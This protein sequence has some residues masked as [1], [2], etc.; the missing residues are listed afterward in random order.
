MRWSRYFPSAWVRRGVVAALLAVTVLPGTALAHGFGSRYEL[1]LPKW[2]F[3]TGGAGVVLVSFVV[4]SVFAGREEGA[5][6]Y[7]ARPLDETPLGP[8][9]STGMVQA[10]RAAAV[11]LL[12]VGVIAGLVGPAE[13]NENLLTNLVWVGWWVGY[14]FSVIFLGNTWPVLNPWTTIYDWTTSLLDRDPTAHREYTWGHLP[15]VVLFVAFAWLEIVGPISRNPRVMAGLVVVYSVY[16]WGGMV[17]YGPEPWLANADPFT[18]LYAYLGKFAPLSPADGGEARMY[19]VGLVAH[20]DALHRTGA[21]VFLVAVLYSVTFDG[22]LATPE[23]R[24]LVLSVPRL[25]VQF[26][27]TTLLMLLMLAVFVGVYVAFGEVMRVA[28]DSTLTGGYLARRFALSLLPI[29]I[30]YQVAHFYTFLLVQ[31]QFLVLALADPFGLGW[32]L[33]GIGGFAPSSQVPF[34]SVQFVWQ[35]QVLLIVLGHVVAVWVAHHVALDVFEDRRR[36]IKS[37]VPMM[38]LMILY[39]MLS[40]WILTRPVVEPPL[41]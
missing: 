39:T 24:D 13:F 34:L 21:L 4:V 3:V 31:G 38:V 33:L 7:T 22:F 12:V 17:V 6:D 8:L 15:A 28:A 11:V 27:T 14:T 2:L 18:R 19:G 10:A 9:L 25:P 26:A 20:D 32:N 1:S 5:F 40:L 30:V 41:V 23:W 35:S 29:A 36:A 16:L 37:Q